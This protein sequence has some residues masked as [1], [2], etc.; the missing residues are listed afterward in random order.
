VIS[1]LYLILKMGM[2]REEKV[3]EVS[4][5]VISLEIFTEARE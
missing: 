1:Y 2:I 5:D 4:K 3:L